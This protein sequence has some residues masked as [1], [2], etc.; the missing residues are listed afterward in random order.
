MSQ[1]YGAGLP[2]P[3]PPLPTE[4]Q[5][6]YQDMEI[7]GFLHFGPNTFSGLEWGKGSEDPK[8]FQPAQ[9]N[10]KQWADT[11]KATGVRGAII[12]AK[13]HDG[14]CLW[15]TKFSDHTVAQTTWRDGKGDVLA[16]FSQA[17]KAANLPVGFYLSPWDRNH[18]TYG[19]PHYNDVFVNMIDEVLSKYG[20]AFEF[21][22]DGANGEGPNGKRQVYDWPRFNT[23]V[24][25]H[26]KDTIIFS[27]GGPGCRWVGNESGIASETNWNMLDRDRFE[28]GTDHS[29]E[30][31]EGHESGTHWVPAECDVSIRPG[32]FWRESENSQVKSVAQLMDIYLKSV[33]RGSNLLLNIPPDSQGLLNESDVKRL[34]EFA[35]ARAAFFANPIWPDS[36]KASSEFSSQTAVTNIFNARP[37]NCWAPLE[38][39]TEPWIEFTFGPART[40][41]T[42]VL[43]EDLHFGQRVKVFRLEE[44]QDSR[45]TPLF[46]NTQD[47]PKQATTIGHKR[48]IQIQPKSGQKLRIV[49][50]KFRALPVLRRIQFFG[51][52]S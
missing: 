39:D 13:H 38:S 3:I 6:R 37:G 42:V 49:F 8:I 16:D 23:M 11:F 19:T 14:F 35:Q 51:K 22:F 15:P 32:W 41:A 5:L 21:W 10:C 30:L 1:P 45:W 33:G 25:S 18:P 29:T 20:P 27:D 2:Q 43:Q 48:I 36:V 24:F 40:P 44:F 28:P 9:L 52:S 31:G 17:F 4:A 12:T 46:Q 50:E 34:Q 26:N 7:V 47:H